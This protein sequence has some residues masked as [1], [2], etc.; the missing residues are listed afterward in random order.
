MPCAPGEHSPEGL[1]ACLPCPAGSICPDG[2]QRKCGPGQ[3]PSPSQTECI[4]CP[5]GFYST[6]ARD[7][8]LQCPAGSYCPSAGTSWPLPCPA[9][10]YTAHPGQLQCQSCNGTS[11][12]G[13]TLG[14]LWIRSEGPL[15]QRSWIPT[16]CRPGTYRNQE[17]GEGP[18]CSVCPLG[19]YCSGG[20]AVPCPAGRYGAKEGIRQERDCSLCPAGF[21][22]L[23][24]SISRPGSQFM[25]P[26]GYYC[27]EGTGV[28]HGTPCPAGTAG[29]QPAQ[30]TRAACKRCAEG[31]FCPEGS[32]VPGL[33]CAR[34]RFCPAGTLEEVSC[35]KGTFTPHQ[36]ATSAKDC[37]KCPA[38]FY[39]PEG[40]SDPLP[41]QPGTF[42]PLEGQDDPADCRPCY[43]GKACT[44]GALKGPDVDCMQGF[45]C[46]PG[47]SRPNPPASACPPGTLSNRTGLTDRSQCQ[48]C[49]PRYA[50]LRGTGGI[51]RPPLACFPGHFCPPG[52]M[53]PT[54]HQ[55]PAGTWSEQVGM[56]SER[57]CQPCPRGWYC[58]PGAGVPSGRCSSGH[59]CPEGTQYGSQYPCPPGTYST[60]MGN[61][62]REDCQ[63]CP[64]GHYCPE[65]TSKPTPC[66]S[67]TFRR[68]KGGQQPQDCSTCPAGY[69][70]PLPATVSPRTCGAGSYSDEGSVECSPCLRGHYCSE[71]TTSEEAMLR[72]MICPPGLLCSQGLDREPQR[73]AT[74]CPI[75]FYCPGGSINPNPI[76]CPNGTYSGQPGLRDVTECVTCPEGHFCF[77]EEPQDRPISELTGRC[78]DG[79]Q[80]PPGTGHPFS[81]PCQAGSFRNNSF[82]H[83]GALCAPCPAGYLCGGPA[84]HTP[85]VCPEGFFC[86]EGSSVPEP[87]EEG[88]YSPRPALRS[89]SECSPCG[90]GRYCSGV[91]QTAP[92]GD[93]RE[94]FYCRERATS[95]TPA[96]GPTGGL[97]PAG[98]FCPS[99]SA[100]P[101][102]CPPGTFSNSTGL[103]GLQQC[104]NCPPGYYCSG[105]NSTSPTG[106]CFAGHYCPTGSA[107][108]T[109]HE[110]EKGQYS[111]AG[112]ARAQLC[113]LGTFQP[114]RG[115]ASCLT[116]ERGRFWLLLGTDGW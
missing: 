89:A 41:C 77:S 114:A 78:P 18:T 75:G 108:P 12:C 103:T 95:A 73:S 48:R 101:T 10:Q 76:P 91:G 97:C 113:P 111:T 84:T 28:P 34:G 70:C 94:G 82:G 24:G 92:S 27:E 102:P 52:T 15:G 1:T 100:A 43:P 25:C 99:G 56:Q 54:Q 60:K 29:G 39:C 107:S 36:G 72:V 14:P 87:C 115:Q 63:F 40:T 71:E 31:R 13:N 64:E 16:S 17:V 55:C 38:G 85:S 47:S 45:V 7:H 6:D 93:C 110:V 21:Y 83:R 104:A 69:S 19:H 105:S 49:P 44:Q 51:Q 58:L 98:S 61:G 46:P 74:L 57:E 112:A 4:E 3:E 8:C 80:C 32:A 66:P 68:L 50:C 20:V 42:N 5:A 62:H 67:R 33:P 37:L 79:H 11:H 90:G 2:H 81:F 88:T 86:A 35:P 106:P 59:Y 9:G 22:C 53:Y 116:C 109:Q 23:E 65:G 30:T 26:M 96:D